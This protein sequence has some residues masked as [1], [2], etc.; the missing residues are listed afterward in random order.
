MRVRYL[1]VVVALASVVAARPGAA[2]KV[3]ASSLAPMIGPV[4]GLNIFS[5]TGSDATGTK[6]L[7]TITLGGAASFQLSPSVFLEPQL[8]Y[9]TKG[10]SADLGGV[11]AKFSIHYVDLPILLGVRIPTQSGVRPYILA[12][13]V[14]GYQVSCDISATSG[15]TTSSGNCKDNG[16]DVKNV[17]YGVTAGAGLEFV[18]GPMTLQAGARYELGLA[19]PVSGSNVKNSG[20]AIGVGALFSLG[21]RQ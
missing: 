21:R 7:S 12:G 3:K 2:Q 5:F 17:N 1:A 6:S 10:A 13:G 11:T 18:A 20:I 4:V 19:Q 14:V 9:S 15:G 8:L 16:I